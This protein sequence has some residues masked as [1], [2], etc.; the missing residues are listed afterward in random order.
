[1]TFRSVARRA[2]VIP[3]VNSPMMNRRSLL[4]SIC[5]GTAVSLRPWRANADSLQSGQVDNAISRGRQYLAGQQDDDGAWRSER[6]AGFRQGDAITPLSLLAL[7]LDES[8]KASSRGIAFLGNLSE[9]HQK[10]EVR[11]EHPVYTAALAVLALTAPSRQTPAAA[12]PWLDLLRTHQLVEGQD[13]HPNDPEYGGWGY[14]TQ[15]PKRPVAG[16]M[17]QPLLEPNL[18]ATAFALEALAAAAPLDPAIASAAGFV[19]RCQNYA[20]DDGDASFDDGGF[21]LVPNSATRNKAGSA[22]RD[23]QGRERFHSYASATADGIRAIH[24]MNRIADCPREHAALGWLDAHFPLFSTRSGNNEQLKLFAAAS[25]HYC[26]F[27]LARADIGCEF[28]SREENAGTRRTEWPSA[29]TRFLLSRQS[30]DGSWSNPREELREDDPLLATSLA[31]SAL[32]MCERC[33]ARA[34][35]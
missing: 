16:E 21:V 30:V 33:S 20:N 22:G 11:F 32:V 24:A 28:F 15:R 35:R 34:T 13:W 26:C 3:A 17:R 31:V 4:A 19:E 27:A 12:E 5:C 10:G 7:G 8:P 14:A 25:Y 6:Y 18:S 29:I 1:M 9:R 23:R 2:I